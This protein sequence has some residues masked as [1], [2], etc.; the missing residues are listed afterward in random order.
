MAISLSEQTFLHQYFSLQ[1][2]QA[3]LMVA[4]IKKKIIQGTDNSLE[5]LMII[6]ETK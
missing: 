1:L 6:R 4:E 2:V 3:M 5:T